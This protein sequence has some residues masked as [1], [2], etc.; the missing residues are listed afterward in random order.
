MGVSKLSS[1]TIK[2]GKP[3]FSS[4]LAGNAVYDPTPYIQYLVIGGGGGGGS[5]TS[6]N[7]YVGGGGGAGGYR[8]SFAAETSGGG[9]PTEPTFEATL[10]T[11]YYASVGAGGSAG[12]QTQGYMGTPSRFGNVLSHGGGQGGG[13]SQ[14]SSQ[15]GSE[16]AAGGAAPITLNPMPGEGYASGS[17]TNNGTSSAAGGGGGAGGI[18]GSA[19][20]MNGGAG[21]IGLASLITGASTQ[22]AGGGGGS[23]A[24]AG[25]TNGSGSYGGGTAEAGPNGSANTGGGGAGYQGGNLGGV[26]GSGVI[27]LR[28]N[29]A[30]TCTVSAGL[31]SSTS[32]L[33]S[34]KITTLTAGTGTV[35]WS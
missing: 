8:T 31:T 32:T 1:G 15:G 2:N 16:G 13:A 26:G 5:T 33:G 6:G 9:S 28:Y 18:G 20:G 17:P 12:N 35:T 34:E 11:A 3:N 7:Q 21:G 27:I 19:S 23:R 22:R 4:M 10:G 25:G 14:Y 29:S 24:Y 30:F